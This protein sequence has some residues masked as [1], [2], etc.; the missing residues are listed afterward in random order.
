MS[1]D[2]A[3]EDVSLSE[4]LTAHHDSRQ[5]DLRVALPARVTAYNR[6]A[7]T[8]DVNICISRSIPDG[9]GNYLSEPF[10]GLSDVPIQ[11]MRCKQFALTFPL[12]VGDCGA[13]IFC[14]RNI[15]SWRG[16]GGSPNG[17]NEPVDPG[18]LGMNTFDGAFFVPGLFDDGGI[19]AGADASNMRIGL[20]GT[21]GGTIDFTPGGD[22]KVLAKPLKNITLDVT[23]GG[24]AAVVVNSGALHVATETDLAGPYPITILPASLATRNFKTL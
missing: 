14:D 19:S 10:P 1:D 2:S 24:A 23:T 17:T 4:L 21:S 20:D 7:G 9:S 5:G 18:D 3:S 15:G 11:Y 13:L 6:T 12:A 16:N 8:V 22:V